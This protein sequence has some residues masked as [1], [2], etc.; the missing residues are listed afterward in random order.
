MNQIKTIELTRDCEVVQIPHGTTQLLAKGTPVDITQTLGGSYT[1]HAQG[2]LF[3][4]ANNDADA[5]GMA[6]PGPH[7]TVPEAGGTAAQKASSTNATRPIRRIATS[8]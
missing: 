2:A 5:L 1:I 3:R 8:H 7:R 4:V 6:V